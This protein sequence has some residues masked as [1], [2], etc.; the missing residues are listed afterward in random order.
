MDRIVN[1]NK[2]R[3]Q[4]KRASAQRRAAENRARFGR[5]KGEI[6]STRA[7]K[8]RDAKDLDDHRRE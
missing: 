5:D 7:L 1:L 2:F 6:S 3:K 4:Q 8:A